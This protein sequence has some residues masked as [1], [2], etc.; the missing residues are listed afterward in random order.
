[1]GA[2]VGETETGRAGGEVEALRA[3][4][5]RALLARRYDDAAGL[6]SRVATMS[7]QVSDWLN[8][9][10]SER[11]RGRFEAALTAVDQALVVNPREF[12]ALLMKASLLERM[13]RTGEAMP[14]YGTAILMAPADEVLDP[15]TRR[16]L[17]H[18][19]Q[20]NRAYGEALTD[21]LRRHVGSGA[22]TSGES[23]R[24]SHFVDHLVGRRKN[25]RQEPLG[26]FYPGL[27]AIEFWEREEFLWLEMLEAETDSILD[28]LRSVLAADAEEF[29]PYIQYPD[30]SPLDQWRAL[31][32][33][34]RWGAYHLIEN[35]ARIEPHCARCPKTL[36][37]LAQLPQPV[38]PGRSPSA[39]FSA[40]EAHTH[41][42]PHTGVSNTRLVCH[43]PLIV[44]EGCW[45][46]V[47]NETRTYRPREAWVFD[48]TIEHEAMNDSDEGR[49]IL[50]FDVWNPRLSLWEREMI[51][52]VSG[53]YDAFHEGGGPHSG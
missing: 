38:V 37:T 52:E 20:A 44:P 42:P 9:A 26:Y 5:H 21:H 8:L 31:N 46:R 10:A 2:R 47:G 24:V 29:A 23:R 17:D 49:V 39:M 15:P 35:G 53:A 45:F 16:A 27:P 51:A 36:E 3:E 32:R 25:Y 40:L 12:A 13:G 34:R 14:L 1:M 6:W 7:G 30:H 19:R 48:D 28:E 33:S 50:L 4:A 43:L 11:V 18:A 41:I 22:A